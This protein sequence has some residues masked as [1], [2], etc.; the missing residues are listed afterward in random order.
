MPAD[1]LTIERSGQWNRCHGVV[2]AVG[3]E[4]GEAAVDDF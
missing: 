1:R 3:N 2:E 4:S